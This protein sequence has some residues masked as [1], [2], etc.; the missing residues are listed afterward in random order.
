MSMADL[1]EHLQGSSREKMEAETLE[2]LAVRETVDLA[3]DIDVRNVQVASDYIN[4]ITNPKEGTMGVYVGKL[5][6]ISMINSK[7]LNMTI[8]AT[9]TCNSNILDVLNNKMNGNK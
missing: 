8:P 1:G 2:A 9:T 5:G 3:M 6:T 4:V 7:I